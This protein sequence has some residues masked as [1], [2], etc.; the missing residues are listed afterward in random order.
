MRRFY[1]EIAA[2]GL[3]ACGGLATSSH[4]LQISKKANNQKNE[5]YWE[6][7]QVV[8]NGQPQKQQLYWHTQTK[9]DV[10]QIY[11]ACVVDGKPLATA[12]QISDAQWQIKSKQA[13]NL[14]A[15]IDPATQKLKLTVDPNKT[16]YATGQR[17][18]KPECSNKIPKNIVYFKVKGEQ[19]FAYKPYPAGSG[20]A[21]LLSTLDKSL[22]LVRDLPAGSAATQESH[23]VGD[24]TQTCT[25]STV[26][27]NE[28]RAIFDAPAM[29]RIPDVYPGALLQGNAYAKG[30]FAPVTIA[31]SGG[32]FVI[33][34]LQFEPGARILETVDEV[35]LPD[36][37][38]AITNLLSQKVIGTQ[39]SASFT[40]ANVH[41]TGELAY[42]L[43]TDERFT[44]PNFN[45][46]M[47]I[48]SNSTQN[49]VVAR[50]TQVYYSVSMTPPSNMEDVF[51][52]G[53]K[54]EDRQNQIGFEGS[55]P[56]GIPLLVTNV[57]YG[58]RIYLLAK[59]SLDSSAVT[60]ALNGAF[61]NADGS[62][63]V[64]GGMTHNTVLANTE[65]T[66]YVLGGDAVETLGPIN[67]ASKSDD[68]FS[69]IKSVI[70]N[71][72]LLKV[73]EKNQGL[74]VYYTATY[75]TSNATAS[76]GFATSF[77]L[78]QCVTVD[79]KYHSFT[80]DVTGI[81]DRAQVTI[82]PE[83]PNNPNAVPANPQVVY[84]ESK[85][86]ITGIQLDNFTGKDKRNW[87]VRIQ[88]YND[89]TWSGVGI[90]LK[91]YFPD[92]HIE[93]PMSPDGN[94]VRRSCRDWNC[95]WCVDY[96]LLINRFNGLVTVVN[97]TNS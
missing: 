32:E 15:T 97:D 91:H 94:P 49:Y 8:E 13:K 92:G 90:L 11:D 10:V 21:H 56:G 63:T 23:P 58:R 26:T 18:Q 69:K 46:A 96:R 82:W 95:F 80:L 73:T 36:V 75:L 38:Q 42:Q 28:T 53:D 93:T 25:T 35:S 79:Y 22:P 62:A 41:S 64:Q 89:A 31:R 52:K 54:F 4:A 45:T 29:V 14:L 6:I 71:E 83:D 68:M 77:P 30:S 48:E 67:K 9:A 16:L 86:P 39:A 19:S 24:D 57:S 74:P 17:I 78:R 72:K 7:T 88:L 5:R 65:I 76:L 1:L 70:A 51:A 20:M 47:N 2:L 50:F 44:N 81:D 55:E 85:Y 87:I 60:A 43:G 40:T 27:K 37:S 59:S 66:Y 84:A 3:V 12:T 33:G 61:A 34:N